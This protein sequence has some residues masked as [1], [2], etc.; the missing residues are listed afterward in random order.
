MIPGGRNAARGASPIEPAFKP[1]DVFI[2]LDP[3]LPRHP[4]VVI[5]NPTPDGDVILVNLTTKREDSDTTCILTVGDHPRVRHD[6]VVSYIDSK[7]V[8]ISGL[9]GLKAGGRLSLQ[10]PLR[11]EVLLRIQTGA[12]QSEDVRASWKGLISKSIQS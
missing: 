8:S 12:L 7:L 5:S 11:P 1:G 3:G 6:T 4:W 2:P 9:R 10:D